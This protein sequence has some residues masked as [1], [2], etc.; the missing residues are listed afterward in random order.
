[1]FHMLMT[2]STSYIHSDKLLNPWNVFVYML[3]Y[4][5]I[6]I[7]HLEIK[8]LIILNISFCSSYHTESVLH[9]KI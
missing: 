3:V 8:S 2:L 6:P 7:W 9:L 1:M 5:R 4:N